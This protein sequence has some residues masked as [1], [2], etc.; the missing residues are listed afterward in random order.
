MHFIRQWYRRTFSDPQ[1]VILAV[2][3][4]SALAVVLLVGQWLV[5]V[6]AAAVIAYLLEG[7][8]AVLQKRGLPRLAAVVVVFVVFMA[9]TAF[10]LILLVPLLIKQ[11]TQLLQALPAIL[12]EMQTALMRLPEKYPQVISEQWIRDVVGGSQTQAMALINRALTFSAA[13]IVWV[14]YLLLYLILVPLMVF[15]FLKDKTAMMGWFSGLL[16]QDRALAVQVWRD[17]DRQLGNYVRGKFLEILIVWAVSFVVFALLGLPFAALIGLLVGVS[18]LVPYVGATVVTVPI[19]I[20]AYL[21]WGF[22]GQFLYVMIAYAVIQAL[23]GNL[24]APLLF[25]EVVNLHP[26]AII[27]AVLFFGGLWGFWGVFFAIPLA[28]VVRSVLEAWPKVWRAQ[29][30]AMEQERGD[31][32]D[33]GRSAEPAADAGS[34][35]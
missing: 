17:V 19:A 9:F 30:E 18:V 24:L 16:P 33:A 8:V 34:A 21:E 26:V 31:D 28:T 15:F 5:P 3:L 7:Q 4:V 11:I 2:L 29:A 1:V 32:I 12:A 22:E 13:S 25:A 20:V 27:V 35:S 14:V 10:V 23:D 6:F